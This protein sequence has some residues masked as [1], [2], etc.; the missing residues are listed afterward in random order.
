MMLKTADKRKTK[1][2]CRN[3]KIKVSQQVRH[4]QRT[5]PKPDALG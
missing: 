1:M 2:Q 3:I 5:K 4:M